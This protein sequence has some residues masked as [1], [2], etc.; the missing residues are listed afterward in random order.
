MLVAWSWEHLDVDQ[1]EF[2][3]LLESFVG[4]ILALLQG[5][6]FE[7]LLSD[8]ENGVLIIPVATRAVGGLDGA[9]REEGCD[10]EDLALALEREERVDGGGCLF[11]AR[12]ERGEDKGED[13]QSSEHHSHG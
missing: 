3:L 11:A 7:D 12:E 4:D 5:V 9:P 8:H 6:V 10:R 1:I 13:G 2:A